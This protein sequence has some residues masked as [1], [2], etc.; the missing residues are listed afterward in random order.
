MTEDKAQQR[1]IHVIIQRV[2]QEMPDVE[3]KQLQVK[4]PADDDNLWWF[5]LPETKASIQIEG[6]CCPFLIETDLQ[7]CKQALKALT[8][9]EAV[10]IIVNYLQSVKA[11][12]PRHL[13][14]ELYW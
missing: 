4:W 5:D 1:D 9:D 6:A 7:S 12:K 10:T 14:G 8:V 2:T 13:S 11:G 3:V